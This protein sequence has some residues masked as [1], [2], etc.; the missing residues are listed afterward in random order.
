MNGSTNFS[1][2]TAE[3]MKQITVGTVDEWFSNILLKYR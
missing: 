3:T 1:R 2:N